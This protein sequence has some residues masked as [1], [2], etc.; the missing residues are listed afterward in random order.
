MSASRE[1][2]SDHSSAADN[3]AS[4]YGSHPWH[5]F[6]HVPKRCHGHNRRLPLPAVTD[7]GYAS[8]AGHCHGT[9]LIEVNNEQAVESHRVPD[10]S[11][12]S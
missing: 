12:E 3:A 9:G 6:P 2:C 10:V 11:P 5:A 8:L 7:T 4:T 1:R